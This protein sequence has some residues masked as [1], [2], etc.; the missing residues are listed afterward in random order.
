M[1]RAAGRVAKVG[2]VKKI[3]GAKKRHREA[4]SDFEIHNKTKS[5]TIRPRNT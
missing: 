2:V 4:S 3:G 1:H 5:T